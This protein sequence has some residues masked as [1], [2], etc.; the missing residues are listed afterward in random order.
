[1]WRCLRDPMCC[2][3]DIIP[4]CDRHTD[5]DTR[6]WHIP[7]RADS[8]RGNKMKMVKID[9]ANVQHRILLLLL[10]LGMS[11]IMPFCNYYDIGQL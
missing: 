11:V 6:P 8:S 3:F 9:L 10:L 2:S 7:R 5:T 1:M 4:A